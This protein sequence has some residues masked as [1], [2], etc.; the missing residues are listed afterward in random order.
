MIL[1]MKNVKT[2]SFKHRFII[3]ENLVGVENTKSVLKLDKPIFL[4]MTILDL[5]KFHMYEFYYGVLKKKYHKHIKLIYTDTDSY[6]IQT[7]TDDVYKKQHMDFSDYPVE[8]PCHDTTN[9]IITKFLALKPKS[10]A[11][12]IHGAEEEHTKSKGVVK[13]KVKK[14]LTYQN[15]EESLYQTKRHEI[16]YNFIRS[17][18]HQIYSMSQVKQSVSNFE[19]KRL[20]FDAL[21]SLPYGHFMIK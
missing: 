13:H 10:Y 19:S 20:Y 3:N 21:N 6:V 5:S 11:F 12:T 16:T 18:T 9:K 1:G 7:F 8:H 14:E 2:P 17:R 4:G 15:Y